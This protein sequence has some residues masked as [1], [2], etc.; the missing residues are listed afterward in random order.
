[1]AFTN[2]LESLRSA[3][4]ESGLNAWDLFDAWR[5]QLGTCL[6]QTLRNLLL[7]RDQRL[8]VSPQG[9]E[10]RIDLAEDDVRRPLGD[11]PLVGGGTLPQSPGRLAGQHQRTV[12]LLPA[13]QVLQRSLSF[14][15]QVRENLQ[16]VI[17]YEVDRLSPFQ[18]EQVFFDVRLSGT[19]RR[20]DR[21]LVELALC[22]R[23][24]VEPWL[25]RLRQTGSPVDQVTWEDAWPKANLLPPGERPR[26]GT[27]G[28]RLTF[29]LLLLALALGAAAL[30][31]PLWQRGQ[32]LDALQKELGRVRDEAQ[33][34]DKART[35][36]ERA[37]QGSVA[38]LQR[39]A[40]QP[41]M[42]DLLRELTVR[43]PDGTWIQNLN[44]DKGEVQLRGESTQATALIALLE[45]SDG[46][47]GVSFASPVTQVAQ[48][49]AERFNITFEYA[50]PKPP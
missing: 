29:A 18:A 28:W 5:R 49:G 34:V 47:R 26:R 11:L 39:K 35:D 50:R 6:P 46:V 1:M 42:I 38:V 13:D 7:G 25:R 15:P 4:F 16:Q 12:I 48:T 17:R 14:P 22:R 21:I 20:G 27:G 23:D 37:R 2:V 9:G 40:E 41:R 45:K 31:T 44:L 36:L 8:L 43:L 3:R 30:I 33:A 10:A 32:V 24:R 19:S